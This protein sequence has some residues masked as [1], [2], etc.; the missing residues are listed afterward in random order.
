[1]FWNV[2]EYTVFSLSS[3]SLSSLSPLPSLFVIS[4]IF[5]IP[6]L[7]LSLLL[8][9]SSPLSSSSSPRRPRSS[10]RPRSYRCLCSLLISPPSSSLSSSSP[11]SLSARIRPR[12]SC[13]FKGFEV[14]TGSRYSRHRSRFRTRSESSCR[15]Q[16]GDLQAAKFFIRIFSGISRISRIPEFQ[17]PTTTCRASTELQNST[18]LF[19][20]FT[21]S[22]SSKSF[23][24]SNSSIPQFLSIPQ[25]TYQNYPCVPSCRHV[26]PSAPP[27]THALP[28]R[29]IS[30]RATLGNTG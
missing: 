13:R 7:S 26:P 19:K 4:V 6:L 10:R 17:N 11:P 2:A 25:Q 30:R 3:S 15:I 24:S 12:S 20:F 21:S 29:P 5:A 28:P 23:K 27:Y 18:E 14:D 16:A 8:S 9:L 1:M 22:K